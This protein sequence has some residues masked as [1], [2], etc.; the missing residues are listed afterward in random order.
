MIAP[1]RRRGT[2]RVGLPSP[3]PGRC[4]DMGGMTRWS[5]VVPA[6][7]LAVAKTRLRPVTDP[8]DRGA[9]DALV[10]ALLADT[11]AA[12]VRCPAVAEVVVVTDE[13]AAGEVA[14]RL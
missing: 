1:G 6:K 10:L 14:A 2:H 11:V 4:A 3:R 9:H 8:H 5:V 12:A 7:R 13:P